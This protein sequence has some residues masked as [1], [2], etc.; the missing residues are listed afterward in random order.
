M[1]LRHLRY[2]IVVAEELH[3]SR[4]AARLN[5][6]QPPLSQQI[7]QIEDELGVELFR[8]TKRSV[9]L[10]PTG[11]VFIA[12]ARSLLRQFD[13]VAKVTVE[14]SR[15]EV[16]TLLVGTVTTIDNAFYR[17]LVDLLHRFA[18]RYPKVHLGLRTLSVT[19]QIQDLKDS[20]LDIGFVTL[21]VDDSAL[22]VQHVYSEPLVAALPEK[23]PL[24]AQRR[25][26]ARALAEEPYIAFPRRMNPGYVDRVIR[27]FQR[28]GCS[29]NIVHEGDSLLMSL[30]LVSAGVGVSLFPISLFDVP[31]KGIVTRKL[32]PSP[33]VM[34]MGVAYRRDTPSAVVEAFLS[35][36]NA[37]K[38]NSRKQSRNLCET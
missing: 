37:H 15:G 10:T 21:P 26:S 9:K 17:V 27:F 3:F 2:A 11:E 4:A 35:I 18:Q 28:E 16:G 6:S 29:L 14:A 12:E 13:R 31:R 1:E 5:I 33:P 34:G 32:K 8:R 23:H 22:V 7:K 30:A 36:V 20:R 25:I 24:A 19:Q 38:P